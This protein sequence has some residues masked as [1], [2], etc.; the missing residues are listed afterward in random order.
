MKHTNLA[1]A[2]AVTGLLAVGATT[3]TSAP[4]HAAEKEKCYGVA[5]A[6][7]NDCATNTSS[8]AGTSTEDGQKDAF[9]MVPKGLCDRLAGGSTS[10]S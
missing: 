9:V 6:G 5:K 8:C 4:A 10:S 7:Q 3:L 1:V 2:A